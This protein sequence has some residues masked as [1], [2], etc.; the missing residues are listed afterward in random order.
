MTPSFWRATFHLLGSRDASTGATSAKFVQTDMTSQGNWKGIYG[1]DGYN[2]LN[3]A[4]QLSLL[5]TGVALTRGR[6]LVFI[7]GLCPDF[8]VNPSSNSVVPGRLQNGAVPCT[9]AGT[10]Q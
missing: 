8:L 3:D 5:C 4:A 2:G 10:S 7:V 6:H 1:S 9:T